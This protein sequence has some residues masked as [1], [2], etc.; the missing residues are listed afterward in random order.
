[1]EV[2]DSASARNKGLLGRERLA[3]G[4]GLWIRP[5]EAVHTFWMRFPIDLIYL[6]RKGRIR[7]LRGEVRP[8]RL[9]ACLTAHSVLE[10]PSGTI[11]DTQTQLGDTLEFSTAFFN[12]DSQT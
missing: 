7:K 4:E 8:W 9:S 1:M 10:F 12:G 11:R 6:D 2:A 3:P 5:C